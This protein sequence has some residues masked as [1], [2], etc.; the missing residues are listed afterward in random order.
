[1]DRLYI[2]DTTLRDGTQAEDVHLSTADKIRI[3]QKLDDLGVAYIEGGWPA[4][5]PTDE[6]YFKE[7]KNYAFKNS[8]IVPFGSTHSPKQNVENDPNIIALLQAET[9]VITIF[10]KTWDI[11]V[12][13]ALRISN[14]HNLEI[15]YNSVAFLRSQLDELF[16]DAE[17]FFDGFKANPEYALACLQKAH[18]AGADF[19]VL[20]DTNGGSLPGEIRDIFEAVKKNLPE[21]RLGIHAHNDSELAVA[22]TLQAVNCGATHIQGTINGY[23]ERCGNANLCSIIPCLELKM[24]YKCLPDENLKSLTPTANFVSEVANVQRFHRQPFVGRSAFAH[25]GGIHVSA[26]SRN[27]ITYEHIAPEKVGN[28][29]RILLSDLAGQSNI[30]FKAKQ[31]GFYLDKDDP[32]VL[33]L[34]T[35]IKKLESLGYEYSVAEASFELLLNR[36]L[37]RARR[38]F[39]LLGFRV[40]DAKNQELEETISE[41]TVMVKVGGLIEHTASGGNGPVNA[42]DQALRKALERF[43]PNL[44]EMQLLDFKVRVL[45]QA[46]GPDSGTASGVRVLIESGDQKTRWSTVGVSSNIIEASWQALVDSVNYKLFKDDQDKLSK[47]MFEKASK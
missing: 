47:A 34:L 15:I 16:F 21:A 2:Y 32:F 4:S 35:E 9:N 41:A 42:L 18:D 13:E 29:Q 36:T 6:R 45:P 25:K 26:V 12:K 31:H 27:P 39:S 10:G 33:E 23:G 14:E 30:L 24:G 19:L 1:M 3:T 22:N 8:R 7:I 5:N 43:Y 11:H 17:H 28:K 44:R 46:P 38:Y 20:C 40:M 37:G